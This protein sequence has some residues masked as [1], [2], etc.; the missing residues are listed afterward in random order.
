[1]SD[2]LI[3]PTRS[4]SSLWFHSSLIVL[5]FALLGLKPQVAIA[6]PETLDIDPVLQ[7]TASWC[8]LATGEMVF[9]Y[10]NIPANDS[11]FQ[12]GEAKG[13]GAQIFPGAAGYT[14]NGPCWNNCAACA[15]LGAGTVRGLYN[16]ITQYPEIVAITA[17]NQRRLAARIRTSAL[18]LPEVQYEIDHQRPIVA[19]I[20]PGIAGF[21]PPGVSEHAVLIIGY[22]SDDDTVIINDPFPYHGAHMTPPYVQVGGTELA[23]GQYQVSYSAFV[24]QLR[25]GNA[26]YG[27]RVL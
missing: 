26:V 17:G 4:Y 1:M 7:E 3:P 22:D 5:L 19:G 24:E 27:I 10:Y 16:L 20:S 21:L 23:E 11:D 12:C 9:E 6:D 13:E 14:I 18:S 2:Y 8:W 15:Q 25:W